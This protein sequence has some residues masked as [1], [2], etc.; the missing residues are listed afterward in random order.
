MCRERL[1][2]SQHVAARRRTRASLRRALLA[3]LCGAA[4]SPALG[5]SPDVLSCALACHFHTGRATSKT[6]T[7]AAGSRGRDGACALR[8]RTAPPQR[9]CSTPTRTSCAS[10][11]RRTAS[12]RSAGRRTPTRR[13][14]CCALCATR[15]SAATAA[16]PSS[17]RAEAHVETNRPGASAD[18]PSGTPQHLR[19]ASI[20]GPSA[21]MFR[22]AGHTGL[23]LHHIGGGLLRATS[24]L[25]QRYSVVSHRR[26]PARCSIR[27]RD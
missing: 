18:S 1:R 15:R 10:T 9:L 7:T 12:A 11:T 19:V 5:S 13:C 8:R 4:T 14:A 20:L 27:R 23:V 2:S 24:I 17:A 6:R 16:A 26:R 25:T 22:L 3:E 21:V